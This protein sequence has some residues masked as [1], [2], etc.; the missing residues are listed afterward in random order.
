MIRYHEALS[1]CLEAIAEGQSLDAAIASQPSR[2]Q[3][4][5][6]QDTTL[7]Q[8]VRRHAETAPGP[9]AAAE[10]NALSR[11]NAELDTV[12]ASRYVASSR[13]GMFSLGVPR[14]AL[15]GLLLAALL[16]GA[17]FLLA[18]SKDSSTVEAAAFEGVVVD[19]QD[20][21]LTVQTLDTL[22][23]VTVPVDAQVLDENGASIN[24]G[25]IQIGEVITVR[26][27]RVRGG[28]VRALELRRIVDG[29]SGW[30]DQNAPR[31]RQVAQDL[32]DAQQRCQNN[33]QACRLAEQQVTDL[34]TRIKDVASLEDLKQR[35]TDAGGD[36]CR[37]FTT[38]C[39][40]HADVCIRDVPPG[41]A[42]DRLDDA[43][44]RLNQAQGL[45]SN[46]DTGACRQ[47][48]Q[49][50]AQHPALCADKPAASPTN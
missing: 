14:F 26:G 45:C 9:S 13:R 36:G 37:D 32:Q 41:P 4:R 38:F 40:D 48:A 16:V 50:C 7:A 34:I 31:C 10:V 35:C 30:C 21:S 33:P 39:Q 43:R 42:I 11:L 6:R 29:L 24:P 23:Q 49:I 19:K 3:V 22:E 2:H 5:L 27:D 15:A 20:G 17:S 46:R 18:G 1:R 25:A 8:A 28:P 44:T 47:V 12:R